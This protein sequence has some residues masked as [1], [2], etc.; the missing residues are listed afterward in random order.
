MISSSSIQPIRWIPFI[1][2]PLTRT[3]M[4][5]ILVDLLPVSTDTS[6][7]MMEFA[8]AEMMWNPSL[9]MKVQDELD[10]V[11]GEGA[12]VDEHHMTKLHYLHAFLKE[13]L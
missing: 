11:V 7:S 13:T 8:M 12:T 6:S 5:N 9:L 3:N 1:K 10:V 2:T 4:K